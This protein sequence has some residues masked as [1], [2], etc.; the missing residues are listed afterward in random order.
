LQPLNAQP[1]II[2]QERTPL[3]KEQAAQI[4]T[5]LE[6]LQGARTEIQELRDE[7]ARLK[8][9][10]GRPKFKPSGMA[11]G[12]SGGKADGQADGASPTDGEKHKRAGSA[13]RSKTAQLEIHQECKIAPATPVPPRSQFKGYQDYVVQ[14]LVIKAHNTRY[15]LETWL[16][17]EGVW[18]KGQLPASVQGHHFDPT[19][20]GY[21]LYQHHHCHVTQPLLR[22]Q[23]TEWG[24]DISAGQVDAVLSADQGQFHAEKDAILVTGLAVSRSVTVDDSGARHKGENGYVLHIGNELFGWF[25]STGSKSRINFLTQLHAGTV[26]TEVNEETL[27]YL[28]TQG[29]SVALREQLA[30]ASGVTRTL[31]EWRQ[32]LTGLGI[33]DPRHVRTATEGALVGS[34]LEKGFNPELAIVSDGAPQ[35]ALFL[36]A[37]C[38][39]HAERLI[40]KLIPVN[41]E[42]RDAIELVRGQVWDL[43]ADLKAYKLQPDPEQVALLETRFDAIFTQSTGYYTLDDLL[44]RHHRHKSELLLVLKRPDIPLHTNG[45]ET[46]IRDYVKKRKISGGTRSDLGRQCRDTFASLKKTCRKQGVSF[47]R[48]LLDRVSLTNAIAPLSTFIRE[49]AIAKGLP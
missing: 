33:T 35:F 43:Y 15:R 34:L 10:K 16:T 24:I 7:I 25:A 31:P 45:S 6:A 40:H 23:L 27:R 18:L 44:L 9:H 30:H 19:V 20:R 29:L 14:G 8:G 37:L 38:W 17:S 39:I 4:D 49:A 13:K 46:D 21:I 1:A 3:E 48:Y 22:E 36:H 2:A 32:H 26:T 11:E 42:Q 5:L 28:Q 12:T 41:D 47:W